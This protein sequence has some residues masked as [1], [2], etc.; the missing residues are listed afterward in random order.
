[1]RKDLLVRYLN[2]SS[3]NLIRAQRLLLESLADD[4]ACASQS[5]N[6]IAKEWHSDDAKEELTVYRNLIKSIGIELDR[7]SELLEDLKGPDQ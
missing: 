3:T 6:R 4:S 7:T 5:N 1:L 2:A